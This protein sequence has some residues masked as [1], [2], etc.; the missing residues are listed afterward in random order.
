MASPYGVNR[1]GDWSSVEDYR[2]RKSVRGVS[3]GQNGT[4]VVDDAM[5][6]EGGHRKEQYLKSGVPVYQD[7]DTTYKLWTATAKGAGKKIAGFVDTVCELKDPSGK[8]Y[9]SV[10]AGIMTYG[11]VY[12]VWLPV[13]VAAED[14]PARFEFVR[15]NVS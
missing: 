1:Y 14:V 10:D 12:E 6:A 3:K 8:W 5:K 2:W 15:K 7:D 13:E 9:E 11:G 4:I